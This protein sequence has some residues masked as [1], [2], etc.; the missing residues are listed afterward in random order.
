MRDSTKRPRPTWIPSEAKAR[1]RS[2]WREMTF[3]ERTLWSR[4]R[5]R[6]LA[7][8][9]FRRQQVIG[10]FIVDFYCAGSGLVVE[11]DG[12]SHVGSGVRDELRTAK[13]REH[14]IRVIRVTNDD[15]LNDLDAVCEYI[16]NCAQ[17]SARRPSPLTPLPEGEG[18]RISDRMGDQ[19]QQP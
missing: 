3:H 6:R 8:L 2:L 7:G 19:I 12:E 16:L 17:H 5:D 14:G 1:S 4:L 18:D 15:V 10:E 11:V 9:K 13:L